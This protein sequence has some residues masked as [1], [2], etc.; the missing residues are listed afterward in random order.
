[1]QFAHR[2]ASAKL[3]VGGYGVEKGGVLTGS[4]LVLAHLVDVVNGACPISIR[5]DCAKPRSSTEFRCIVTPG[6]RQ[7]V[8]A[9]FDHTRAVFKMGKSMGVLIKQAIV[10]VYSARRQP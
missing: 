2:T 3:T 6:L 5:S 9:R 10:K 7:D 1:M 4:H 8:T